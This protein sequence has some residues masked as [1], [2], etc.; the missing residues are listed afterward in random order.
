L[1]TSQESISPKTP[2]D[3]STI[4]AVT[5]ETAKQR[6]REEERLAKLMVDY[7]DGRFAAFEELYGLLKPKLFQYLVS[8][9][10]D[11]SRA[12]DLLQETFLQ[13]HRSRHTYLPGRSVAPWAFGIARHVYLMY[14]RSKT[15]RMARESQPELELPEI[16]VPPEVEGLAD[17]EIVRSA[18]AKIPS[19]QREALLMHHVW[20]LS[21]KEIGAILGIRS[22]TAKLR[23][24]RGLIGIREVVQKLSNPTRGPSK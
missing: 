16:P 18:L 17:R 12:E 7:Q 5:R 13:V 22:G 2:P 3:D 4:E 1:V 14:L 11:K 8:Q 21:F 15:R 19:L 23:S 6:K 9:T 24:H 20:G 10:L